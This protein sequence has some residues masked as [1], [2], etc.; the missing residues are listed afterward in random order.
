MFFKNI[1]K[2]IYRYLIKIQ[3]HLI[4]FKNNEQIKNHNFHSSVRLN[5][6]EIIGNVSIG[7]H[8]YANNGTTFSSGKNSKVEIGR[9]CAIGRYV[10]IT[11]KGHSFKVPTA[12]KNNNVNDNVEKDTIVCDYVWIGDHVFIKHGVKI[13]DFAIIGANSVVLEDVKDFEIVGGVPAKHIR[14]N[15]EH[16]RYSENK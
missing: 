12:D 16:Y 11:S 3:S 7:Q 13:G 15:V 6:C 10:H 8:T 9:Y 4:D 1:K 2:R 5:E 14:Y